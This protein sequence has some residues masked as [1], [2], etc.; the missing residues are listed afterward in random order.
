MREFSN[1]YDAHNMPVF[2]PRKIFLPA[3]VTYA[4]VQLTGIYGGSPVE[5]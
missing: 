2:A 3:T 1:V 5:C 4:L